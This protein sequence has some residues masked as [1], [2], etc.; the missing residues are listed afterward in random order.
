MTDSLEALQ[1]HV[2]KRI[3]DAMR[4]IERGNV[5]IAFVRDERGAV[6]GTL[7][8]GDI[9]RALLSG[10]SLDSP[11]QPH[12]ACEFTSV[13]TSA[14]RA[15]IL[16][17][18]QARAIAQVPVLDEGGR[19]QG[20]HTLRD[21]V[22]MVERPNWAVIMAG[23]KG[24]RLGPITEH[25]PKSMLPVAG[26]PI[27]ER[28]VLNLVGFGVR[29][30]YLAV[31]HLAH[32][33]TDHFGD[34]SKLGCDIRYL[35]EEQPL[36]TGG[37][38]TL[39][40]EMPVEPLVVLNGDLVTQFDLNAML[41]FHD[42]GRFRATVAVHTY[43]HT[44]P[45]GVLDIENDC[46]K[47]ITEKPTVAFSANAG[48]YVID[49]ALIARVPLGTEFPLPNLLYSCIEHR[50]RVGAFRIE[51]DWIDVGRAPELRRARGEAENP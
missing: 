21:I 49:P 5:Q 8:D 9:R 19:L 47:D 32:V 11:L 25:V 16:E 3:I 35:R 27:L 45:F 46:V 28:L 4:V 10:A 6:I 33:I 23:G 12:I 13:P 18:M 26:R 24:T 29:R 14:T 42:A 31:N 36:G 50:E 22:G 7:T 2:A 30:I 34:G 38:L 20:V 15:E 37:A 40:P 48:I 51:G 44:V 41:A 39:L 43:T 17:L 1:V